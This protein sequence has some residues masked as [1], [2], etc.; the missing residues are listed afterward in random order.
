MRRYPGELA[1]RVGRVLGRE[2]SGPVGRDGEMGF[3]GCEGGEG[4]GGEGLGGSEW[5]RM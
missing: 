4:L 2:A 5:P 1:V 3:N